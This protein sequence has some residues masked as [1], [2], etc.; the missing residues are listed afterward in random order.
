MNAS[1]CSIPAGQ[2]RMNSLSSW[3][4]LS[5]IVNAH[6]MESRVKKFQVLKGGIDKLFQEASSR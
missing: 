1:S 2:D 5:R 3:W 4:G 6:D